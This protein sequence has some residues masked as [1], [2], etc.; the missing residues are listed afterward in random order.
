MLFT[1]SYRVR[2]SPL[3]TPF[4]YTT[5]FQSEPVAK[6]ARRPNPNTECRDPKE[7]RRPKSEK[8]AALAIFEFRISFGIRGF[9]FRISAKARLLQPALTKLGTRSLPIQGN[10]GAASNLSL[11]QKSPAFQTRIP[12]A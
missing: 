6:V 11:L 2:H 7:I 12:N 10:E 4:P 8:C 3:S 9:G 1:S 5:L